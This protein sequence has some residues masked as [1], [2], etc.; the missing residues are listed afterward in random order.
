MCKSDQWPTEL[1]IS[2][3]TEYAISYSLSYSILYRLVL[4]SEV[5]V[6][7]LLFVFK[8][9]FCRRLFFL[10]IHVR[11]I[12]NHVF[13]FLIEPLWQILMYL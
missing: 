1:A 5:F 2:R 13:V 9:F 6:L 3:Y 8:A 10:F 7:F 11:F 12:Q 4:S